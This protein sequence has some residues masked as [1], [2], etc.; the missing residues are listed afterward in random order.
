M[1][2]ASHTF[3]KS[4]NFFCSTSTC[5]RSAPTS[6]LVRAASFSLIHCCSSFASRNNMNFLQLFSNMPFRFSPSSSRDWYLTE[7]KRVTKWARN[8]RCQHRTTTSHLRCDPR[9]EFVMTMPSNKGSEHTKMRILTNCSFM[10][11]RTV[12]WSY[13]AR[14]TYLR[15][16]FP[17]IMTTE[18]WNQA[19]S[20]ETKGS[21][22]YI[23]E[24]RWSY[25]KMKL[26]NV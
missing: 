16:N 3:W 2:Q 4:S 14:H 10:D 13:L 9:H 19:L 5:S 26:H 22:D 17:I 21:C 20:T 23:G 1:L 12:H 11:K 18:A 25:I 24:M 15:A 8:Q 7:V 6:S